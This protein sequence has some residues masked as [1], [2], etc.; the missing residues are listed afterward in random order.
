MKFKKLLIFRIVSLVVAIVF[1][2][3][4]VAYGVDLSKN[5]HLRAPL[6]FNPSVSDDKLNGPKQAKNEV[7]AELSKPA[8][9]L[10]L[11]NEPYMLKATQE[12]LACPEIEKMYPVE[13][14]L[15]FT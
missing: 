7:V 1:F 8:K 6:L 12:M 3:N 2:F 11:D 4:S 10:I 9:V 14:I 13:N 5:R 15:P